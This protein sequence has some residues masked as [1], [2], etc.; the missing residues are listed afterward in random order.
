MNTKLH[1]EIYKLALGNLGI[2]IGF[3]ADEV[4]CYGIIG[5]STL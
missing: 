1:E 5:Q 4:G 2:E 3:G